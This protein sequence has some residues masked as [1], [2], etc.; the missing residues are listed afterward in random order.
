MLG[1][2]KLSGASENAI[3]VAPLR[4]TR[5]TSC[6]DSSGDQSAHSGSGMKRPGWLPAHSS[7]CQSL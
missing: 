6:A 4:A 1:C 7:M 5:R 3:A 2:P